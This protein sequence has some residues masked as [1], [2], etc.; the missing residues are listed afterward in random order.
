MHRT[1]WAWGCRKRPA[2]LHRRLVHERDQYKSRA[3]WLHK[4]L[5]R[6]REE[7]KTPRERVAVGR[8][9]EAVRAEEVGRRRISA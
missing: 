5:E 6:L 7:V 4:Q 2:L 8:G 3:A 1:Q 9:R